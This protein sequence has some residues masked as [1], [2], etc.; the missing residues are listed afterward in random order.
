MPGQICTGINVAEV[1]SGS[2]AAS[3]AGMM[4][5]DN[6]ARVLK[7]EP[8]EGDVA[9][10][11]SP[12]GFL[13]WNRG[14]ESL[15]C[16]L[17]EA[18]GRDALRGLLEHTDVLLIGVDPRRMDEWEFGFDTVRESYPALVYTSISGFG[19]RGEYARLKAYEGVVAAKVGLYSRGIFGPREGPVFSG[20]MIA[21]SGAAHLAVSGTL[22]A[23][24]VRETT[25]RGQRVDTSLVQGLIAADYFGVYQAQL[26]KRMASG[27]GAPGTAPGDGMAASRY[28]LTLCTGDGRWVS[29]SPQQPHQ[30]HALLRAV[31]LAWTLDDPRYANAPFFRDAEQAQEWEDI[32]SET[33]RSQTYAEI[34]A[35]LLTE[36]DI[37]FEL[38][39]T[40]EEALDHPQIVANGDVIEIEDPVVGAIRE[41][42]PVARLSRTPAVT[43]HSAPRLGECAGGFARRATTGAG[44]APEHALSGTT[45]VEFGYFYA[46]PYAMA[47]AASLGAR[48]IKLEDATGDPIRQAFGGASGSAKVME[49]KESLSID[50]KSAAGRSIV[51][52]L[53]ERANAFVL[54]FRPGVAERLGIDYETLSAINPS[55]VYVHAAGYGEAGPYAHRPVYATT[56]MAL[57]GSVARH[58]G[59]WMDPRLADGLSVPEL[60]AVVAPHLRGLIDGDSNASLA[61]CTALMLGLAHQRRT[62]EGQFVAT[63]MIGGN[64]YAYTDDAVTYTGKPPLPAPDTDQHGLSALYRLYRAQDDWIFVA[65]TNESEW[66]ALLKVA[67][68]TDL[69][70][71]SRF[72]TAE[73]R[74]ANDDALVAVLQSVFRERPANEW[75][76]ALAEAD[77]GCSAVYR[78]DYPMGSHPAFVAEDPIMLET[79]M[80][81]DIE[82]PVFGTIRRHGLPVHF[83]ETPGRIATSYGRGEHTATILAELGYS[84]DDIA[85]LE[86]DGVVFGPDVSETTR[87]EPV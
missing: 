14:K 54:G 80:S 66:L 21:S 24:M 79:G 23:L 57:A 17:R 69:V 51:H 22:A 77:V 55:L 8:P 87:K 13:V 4:L 83:S 61:A 47:M 31:G 35:Q 40:S 18:D 37:P 48:V 41:I 50:L 27:A 74:R 20:N 70:D 43:L 71:D 65:A 2:V 86:R 59:S 84:P 3:L 72:A 12:S 36:D 6:G 68:R 60:Q 67:G 82:H 38:C 58:A 9:R 73:S 62:G 26:A 52:T 42:G 64:L 46:M 30:A 33:F 44:D 34:E 25:G 63:S 19:P 16:D 56:A 76:Q 85:T 28:A 5:A 29:L 15:V 78:S 49:G 53:I 45:I 32:V 75:E 1:G 10:T 7:I 11:R 81:V 39:R